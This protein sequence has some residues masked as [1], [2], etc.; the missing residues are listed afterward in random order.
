MMFFK[1]DAQSGLTS[2]YQAPYALPRDTV[3]YARYV[4]NHYILLKRS[5]QYTAS[6]VPGVVESLVAVKVA[7]DL[8]D[9]SGT[10][11]FGFQLGMELQHTVRDRRHIP[12]R[13]YRYEERSMGGLSLAMH[14]ATTKG[15]CGDHGGASTNE[16]E[17]IEMIE[18]YKRKRCTTT[19]GLFR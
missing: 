19:C 8:C 6:G 7:G 3:G 18:R 1:A 4:M 13:I 9:A 16:R 11:P 10:A 14:Q 12:W 5:F 17:S 2:Y 15:I